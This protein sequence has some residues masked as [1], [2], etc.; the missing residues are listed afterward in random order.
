[1]TTSEVELLAGK[2]D[3]IDDRLRKMEQELAERRGADQK[4]GSL[5]KLVFGVAG[6]AAAISAV[7]AFV[8]DRI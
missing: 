6:M 8:M 1:M 3:K 4:A 7:I 2:L 5:V